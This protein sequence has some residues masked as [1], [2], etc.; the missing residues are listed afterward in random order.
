[1]SNALIQLINRV[2]TSWPQNKKLLTLWEQDHPRKRPVDKTLFQMLLLASVFFIGA[3]LG[4]RL[5]VFTLIPASLTA[6]VAV[7][8]ANL[9]WSFG[10]GTLA[11]AVASVTTL[12]LGYLVGNIV[13]QIG[14]SSSAPD[15]TISDTRESVE[16]VCLSQHWSPTHS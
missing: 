1:L 8:S 9:A 3:V 15:T 6:A 4:L 2:G 14:I 12:Q 11:L 16:V 5:N 7:P 13:S 10:W